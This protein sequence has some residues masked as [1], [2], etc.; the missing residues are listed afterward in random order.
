MC[1]R[2]NQSGNRVVNEQ[3]AHATAKGIKGSL[4]ALHIKE[5]TSLIYV[6]F[7]IKTLLKSVTN[8]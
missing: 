6:I 1:V 3:K 8:F 7:W 2:Y 5:D 4:L